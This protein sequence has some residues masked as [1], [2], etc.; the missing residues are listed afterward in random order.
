MPNAFLG[1]SHSFSGRRWVAR[2]ADARL[3]EALAQRLGV[4]DQLARALA[5]RG[6]GLDDAPTFLEPKLR[7]LMPDPSRFRDMDAAVA[8]VARALTA[9][10]RVAV[11][12]DYDVDGA[13]SSALL[14]RFARA[15]GQSWRLYIPD[16]LRE[17]YGPNPAAMRQLADEG[18]RLVVCVDCGTL[19]F[20]A[21]EAARA[22]GLEVIVLD[23]HAA[24]PAL[25]PAVAVVN[26]NRIDEPLAASYGHLAACGV[27][28]LF[29]VAVNRALRNAGFYD[30]KTPPDLLALLDLVALGT[31]CDVVPL[32]GL[33]RAFVAQGLKILAGRGNAGLAALEAVAGVKGLPDAGTLGFVLGPRLNAGGRV[34]VSDWGAR[35]LASDDPAEA[36]EL[37]R[38]LNQMNVERQ[39]VEAAVLAEA[40]TRVDTTLPLLFMAGEGWHPGVIGI[41]ASRLKEKYH[42][43]AIVVGLDGAVGK[44]S[45][46]SVAGLD[47]GAAVI[48]AK[49]A[50]LLVAGGGH[51]MAAGLTVE[52]AK[53]DALRVFL[54]ERLAA[55]GE[56]PLTPTL[57]LDGLI[58]APAANAAFME[59]L[60]AL[61]PFGTGNPEPR[62]AVP[63]CRLVNARV[64]GDK[65]VSVVATQGGARLRAIAFRAMGSDLGPALL[66][67]HE[68]C[69][70]AG[71]LRLDDWRG[72]GSVQLIIDDAG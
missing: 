32:T 30:G 64:V 27:T 63:D 48:A 33:N 72:D 31:V 23:H 55:A 50:G 28:Y 66:A 18:A 47:L 51:K 41:V 10:E 2:A 35:L 57:T 54:T 7:A 26:P 61:Q 59:K 6:V 20:E 34:G 44:G 9:G 69:A 11:F 42:R 25:P 52:R 13:T 8:R 60:A 65:H 22:A 58:A 49:Q 56:G 21:L 53:I 4:P 40:E 43:P 16:R 71:K 62:F 1:V 38:F 37:A 19:A 15:V 3:A 70:L 29:L 14:M 67:C 24:E 45:G 39:E 46:R 36:D 17:G 68:P 12:G 5:G